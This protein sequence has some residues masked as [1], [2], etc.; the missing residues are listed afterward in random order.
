MG[1]FLWSVQL[2]AVISPGSKNVKPDILSHL[3]DVDSPPSPNRLPCPLYVWCRAV[4]WEVE[5]RV[6][7]ANAG[8]PVPVSC[9]PNRLFV[10]PEL[11]LSTGCTPLLSPAT[12]EPKGLYSQFNSGFRGLQWRWV[13]RICCGV[14]IKQGALST[15]SWTPHA[16]PCSRFSAL[17]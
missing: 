3:F 11:R 13:E 6:R 10:P 9:P 12:L 2:H 17:V 14:C 8:Q 4:S 1:P 16:P 15:T 7:W 5:D